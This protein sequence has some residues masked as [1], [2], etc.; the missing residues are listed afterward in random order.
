MMPREAL[1]S[2]PWI[3]LTLCAVTLATLAACHSKKDKA[4]DPPAELVDFPAT[5][6]VQ[7]VWDSGVGGGGEKLRLGLGVAVTDGRAFAAGHDGDVEAFDL[8]TG[9]TLWHAKTKA[10]LSGGTGAGQG[11]VVV[12]SSEGAVIALNAADG[13]ERWRVKVNGE[14][15][16][17]PAI[18]PNLVIVRAVDG[19]LHALA[20]DTGKQ[21]W[22][23]EQQVPRLSLRG[24]AIPVITNNSV[25]CGFD[26]GKVVALSLSDGSLLWEN[27]VAPPHG[28][29]EL[30][31]LVDIDSAVEVSGNN[32]YA[33]GFQG[34]VAMIMLD[35]GQ[36]WWAQDM[37]SYRGLVIDD[38]NVYIS[39]AEG[40]VV[41]L[42]RANGTEVWRQ[43][44]L[45]HRGL[46]APVLTD[47]AVAVADFQGY[48]HWLDKGTGALAG[49]AQAGG[50]RISNP[51][52][53]L[54]DR[55]I[56]IND[57]GK[58]TEFKTAPIALAQ[59]PARKP[60]AEPSAAPSAPAA[61]ES[62]APADEPSEPG[63]ATPAEPN[64]SPP[65]ATPP[66][67][68]STTAPE[69]APPT[70][71]APSEPA[72][73]PSPPSEAAPAPSTSEPPA[74]GTEPSPPR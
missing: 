31:R 13:N 67:E 32:V 59:A 54:G 36:T 39:T 4:V 11:L 38:Q 19:K 24:T 73:P 30:E 46:S 27:T 3:R 70:P 12:G 55:V 71:V 23:Y 72:T 34:R 64:A 25:I 57:E 68:P 62:S 48:V 40:E 61:T 10:P 66:S 5:L 26:N 43:K 69:A 1:R 29:T 52:I 35:S 41:A 17:A 37:S 49:R 53:G 18:A 15:L 8:K 47:H 2:R 63:A 33:V 74:A 45:A 14:V 51:P 28:R 20:S 42:N 60:A 9:R 16:S 56:V 6:R 44:A 50:E 7:K 22:E 21:V 65:A 58:L